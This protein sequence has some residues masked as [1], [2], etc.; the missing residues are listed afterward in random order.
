MT[1]VTD[2]ATLRLASK[3]F[4]RLVDQDRRI[5]RRVIEELCGRLREARGSPS[6]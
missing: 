6:D 1:A 5:A 3:D 4:L 2:V